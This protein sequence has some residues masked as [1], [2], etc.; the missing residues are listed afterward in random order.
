MAR[1]LGLYLTKGRRLRGT[2]SFDRGHVL[3]I[4]MLT[5]FSLAGAAGITFDGYRIYRENIEQGR[6][7]RS[8]ALSVF[9]TY[10]AAGCIYDWKNA[11]V[12]RIKFSLS[13]AAATANV[14]GSNPSN[15]S[16]STAMGVWQLK[17]VDEA[18]GPTESFA[19]IRFGGVAAPDSKALGVINGCTL[20]NGNPN[21]P[22]FAEGTRYL[23]VEVTLRGLSTTSRSTWMAGFLGIKKLFTTTS[24]A[25]LT[26]DTASP[27]SPFREI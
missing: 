8:V 6:L 27:T 10:A 25:F 14:L 24:V 13:T 17:M 21:E 22:T 18:D 19:Q 7:A 23:G 2:R 26:Y 1:K 15:V 12:G 3:I 20:T 11:N 16:A 4:S 9:K 5:M